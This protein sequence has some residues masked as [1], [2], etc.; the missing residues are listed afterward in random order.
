MATIT[1]AVVRELA[2]GI[3]DLLGVQAFS[4]DFQAVRAWCPVNP[5]ADAD[6]A[7]VTVTPDLRQLSRASRGQM[8]HDCTINVVIQR[9]HGDSD[10][11]GIAPVERCDEIADL[12]QEFEDFLLAIATGVIT[13]TNLKAEPM[14]AE[15][16]TDDERLMTDGIFAVN[17]AMQYKLWR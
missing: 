5:V 17:I 10:P 8:Q 16:E 1:P 11:S 3:V 13:T 6:Y 7:L 4:Q 2:Q 12:A 15:V 9:R 14:G